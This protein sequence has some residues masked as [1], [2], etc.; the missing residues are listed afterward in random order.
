[1]S[2]EL[3]DKSVDTALL[4]FTVWF[5]SMVIPDSTAIEQK[6]KEM[7][8]T[9]GNRARLALLVWSCWIILLDS[10]IIQMWLLYFTI[11]TV[12]DKM[13]DAKREVSQ[14]L[15]PQIYQR[16][17]IILQAITPTIKASVD[18]IIYNSE[19]HEKRYSDR[20]VENAIWLLEDFFTWNWWL[21]YFEI[22]KIQ[23]PY[24]KAWRE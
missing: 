7:M 2:Q 21:E 13:E 15:R 17:S 6:G 19:A 3:F 1:M 5:G 12:L 20:E 14:N 24:I 11:K 8:K 16:H 4:W 23:Y 10:L 18:S 22:A 9:F